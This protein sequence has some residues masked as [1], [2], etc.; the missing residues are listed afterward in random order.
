MPNPAMGELPVKVTRILSALQLSM[1]NGGC[2]VQVDGSAKG[3]AIQDSSLYANGT[4]LQNSEG[5]ADA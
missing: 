4:P 5:T 1:E 3:M 2:P